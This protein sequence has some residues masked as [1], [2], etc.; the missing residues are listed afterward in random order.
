MVAALACCMACLCWESFHNAISAWWHPA[1]ASLPTKAGAGETLL[2][3]SAPGNANSP[4]ATNSKA[5][6]P[7]ATAAMAANTAIRGID[8]HERRGRALAPSFRVSAAIPVG[9][10]VAAGFG[11]LSPVPTLFFLRVTKHG[12][13]FGIHVRK[14]GGIAIRIGIQVIEAGIFH[15]VVALRIGKRIVGLAEMPF[16]GEERLVS[17]GLEHRRQRPF[18][19]RQASA[20]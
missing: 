20:P 6:P 1:Q 9:F 5:R 2:V 10:E 7:I 16:S 4:S 8:I 15:F 17:A 12:P 11:S 19:R 14:P 3:R 18:G 13:Q